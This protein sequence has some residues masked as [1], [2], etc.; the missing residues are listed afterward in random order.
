MASSD[1][2]TRQLFPPGTDGSGEIVQGRLG[3]FPADARIRDTNA[4]LE[5]GLAFCRDL[6]VACW[7]QSLVPRR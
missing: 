4:V 6:L 7:T 2:L 1:L 3:V 5:T